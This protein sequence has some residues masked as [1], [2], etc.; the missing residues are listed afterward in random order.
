MF[1]NKSR[2]TVEEVNLM[3]IF[4]TSN[5]AALMTELAAATRDFSDEELLDIAENALT[6]L[7]KMSDADFAALT[8]Y[9]EYN[10]YDEQEVPNGD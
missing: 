4:D 7:G 1:E 2:F 10:D 3:C 5:R 8:L 9:P 6:K